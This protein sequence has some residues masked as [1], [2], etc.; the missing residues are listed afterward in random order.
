[1]EKIKP[2]KSINWNKME[3]VM[4]KL[5]YEKLC[6]QFWLSTRMVISNDVSDWSKL[7]DKERDLFNKVFG[8]LTALDT[9][10]S[11]DG[12][13]SM[14]KDVR[15]QHETAVLNNIS[16]MECYTK[17]HDVLTPSG[18]VDIS[19]ISV[20]DEV[21]QYND[22]T[23]KTS[24]AKVLNTS[25]HFSE[26]IYHIYS[27]NRNVDLKVSKGHRMVY[28][29]KLIKNN[30]CNDWKTSVINAKDFINLPNTGLRRLI[31][32][33]EYEN[34]NNNSLSDVERLFIALQA[35]G[36]IK[37]RAKEKHNELSNGLD[38]S[39]KHNLISLNFQFSK[40]RKIERLRKIILNS[41]L[42]YTETIE[43]SGRTGFDVKI[44]VEMIKSTD[45]K[46]KNM[47]DI[48]N[49]NKKYALEFLEELGNWDSHIETMEKDNR[50]SITYYTTDKDNAD[51]VMAVATISGTQYH[52]SIR[53]DNRKES[54]KD[55]YA[56][57][58]NF[59]KKNNYS[60]LQRIQ[61][62]ILEGEIVYGVEVPSSFL[63]IRSGA[64]TIISG[65]CE[66]ARSYSSIFSTLCSPKEIDEIFS[67]TE[68]NEFLQYKANTIQEI[69][70]TGTPLQKKIASVF[71]ESFL[72]YSGFYT[73]LYYLGKGSM[74]NVAEVIRLI[75]RD[76]SVHG[77]YL[78][79]K[80]QQAYKELS[81]EEQSELMQWSYALLADLYKNEVKY[82]QYLYDDFG[83][84]EDVKTFLKYNANKA[85]MNLGIEPMFE[86][87][88][89]DVNPIIMN[90]ISTSTSNHDFFSSVGNGYLLT[91]VE[92]MKDSDYDY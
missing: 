86:E 88:K 55:T 15:T 29:E 33:S 57:R 43:K 45:K 35:D 68:S 63:V 40:D 83:W 76:E 78:G 13:Y 19:K 16:F 80:F 66:H 28:E 77:T 67:W 70:A 74:V 59:G 52:L 84:T 2:F 60:T 32:V 12:L 73:P 24:F 90:G 5:T 34:N 50:K 7:S 20:G 87:T 53:K 92:S 3:D 36:N 51:F 65:N 46:F 27:K 61:S 21:L 58:I 62:E 6:Q 14:K 85:L 71:L 25:S 39:R 22:K 30:E 54:Y 23:K 41:N 72:F 37:K 4:D 48:S 38:N 89:E 10:Q 1:M 69:Y 91:E 18:W 75:I 26:N 31:H 81:F 47:F 64:S 82:T 79:Y 17:G 11:E 9:L 42:E 49:F 56:I 8:G 44:P